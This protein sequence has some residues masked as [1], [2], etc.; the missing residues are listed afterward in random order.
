[1]SKR[2][3]QILEEGCETQICIVH[4]GYNEHSISLNACKQ[5]P[6][7]ALIK[8]Q[9]IRELRSHEDLLS[10][11]SMKEQCNMIPNSLDGENNEINYDNFLFI[12][13][14]YIPG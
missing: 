12:S 5:Q 11:H 1:M 4:C 6:S 3:R 8:L 14:E 7:E 13:S 2:H 10:P 9:H